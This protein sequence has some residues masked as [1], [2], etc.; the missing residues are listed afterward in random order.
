M[1]SRAL[2]R[3]LNTCKITVTVLTPSSTLSDDEAMAEFARAVQE[4]R[5]DGARPREV[6][7][8]LLTRDSSLTES[9]H[10]RA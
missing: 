10:A 9:R 1:R 6:R 3:A 5:K 7:A 2:D 8:P 4:S